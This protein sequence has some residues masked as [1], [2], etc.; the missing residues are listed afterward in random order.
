MDD[1]RSDLWFFVGCRRHQ[2]V[3]L[4]LKLRILIESIKLKWR[5][6]VIEYLLTLPHHFAG[7]L[8]DRAYDIRQKALYNRWTTCPHCKIEN[9]YGHRKGCPKSKKEN[10]NEKISPV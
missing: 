3:N 6:S 5:Y 4:M 8:D 2:K 7:W 10:N 1:S 9:G